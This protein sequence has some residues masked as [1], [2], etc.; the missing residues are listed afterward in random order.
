[1]VCS[2]AGRS[3]APRALR[4]S[5]RRPRPHLFNLMSEHWE[6]EKAET[7]CCPA[8]LLNNTPAVSTLSYRPAALPAPT[9]VSLATAPEQQ[10]QAQ[11]ELVLTDTTRAGYIDM[12]NRQEDIN[13]Q[14]DALIENGE[15]AMADGGIRCSGAHLAVITV[16]QPSSLIPSPWHAGT[17]FLER[18]KEDLVR[19]LEDVR[20]QV[21]KYCEDT[22]GAW[23]QQSAVI[24][25][26]R[27]NLQGA[28]AL[29]GDVGGGGGGGML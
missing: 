23:S 25:Q 6:C 7:V 4:R 22:A 3:S 9:E 19:K 27:H 16:A 24:L 17:S 5:L 1:M 29:V 12:A 13:R 26:T 20:V 2:A 28:Q 8:Q 14:I 21:Q 10:Q 11:Q 18:L 15:R